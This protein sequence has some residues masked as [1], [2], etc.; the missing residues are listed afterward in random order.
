[1]TLN[2]NLNLKNFLIRLLGGIPT[3]IEHREPTCQEAAQCLMS[4]FRTMNR[5]NLAEVRTELEAMT[6]RSRKGKSRDT[7]KAAAE[8]LGALETWEKGGFVIN[9]HVLQM[10]TITTSPVSIEDIKID[11]L[12]EPNFDGVSIA[13]ARINR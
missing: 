3:T 5:G 13:N 8:F 12:G 4:A 11:R 2:L 6:I 9:G 1:M 7:L 10:G